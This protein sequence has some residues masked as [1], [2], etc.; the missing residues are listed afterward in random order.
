M[1][2]IKSLFVSASGLKA[3]NGRMR[4]IAENIAN[5]NSTARTPEEET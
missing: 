1:D 4:I 3:Q 5:A 2:L